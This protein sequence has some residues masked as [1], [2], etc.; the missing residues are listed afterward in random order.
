MYTKITISGLICSGKTTLFWDLFKKLNWPT[1][2][3]SHFFRDYAR[4]HG[5]SLQKGEEQNESLTKVI[6]L[7]M[8]ELLKNSE[9][10]ILEGWMAG[11]MADE[12]SGV[13]RVFLTCDD[14]E[15][16]KRFAEREHVNLDQAQT[17]I[18]ERETN[19]Y[20]KLR[21]I[22]KRND[23]LDPKNYNLVIDTT[24]KSPEEVLKIVLDKINTNNAF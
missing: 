4:T 21:D 12:L 2:S 22:Y 19:V 15:R 23:F 8:T 11:I 20:K 13:L 7:G 3:A 10:I 5:T 9:H 17:Q 14:R 6:D 24:D 18:K 16:V 1:F